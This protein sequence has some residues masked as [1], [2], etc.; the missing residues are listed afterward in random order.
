MQDSRQ[1][2]EPRGANRQSVQEAGPGIFEALVRFR[3]LVLGAGAA[4][5]VLAFVVSVAQSSTYVDEASM[6]LTDPRNSGVFDDNATL[7]SEL[8]RYVR[9]QADFVESDAVAARAATSAAGSLS[10]R[11]G[12]PSPLKPPETSIWS[13]SGPHSR[14]LREPP[15]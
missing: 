7:V 3:W 14:L 9:N 8:S 15:T 2:R 6:L 4:A 13:R 11:S 1:S 12:N 5:A 10:T